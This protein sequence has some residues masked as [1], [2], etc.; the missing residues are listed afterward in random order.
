ML[1]DRR[2]MFNCLLGAKRMIRQAYRGYLACQ[3]ERLMRFGVSKTGWISPGQPLPRGW[4]L[5]L[6][7]WVY[8][9]IIEW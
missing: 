3:S 8:S 1:T 5:A 4:Y 2:C 6:E 7:N 9:R